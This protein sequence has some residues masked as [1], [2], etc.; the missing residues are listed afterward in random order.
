MIGG[1]FGLAFVVADAQTPLGSVAADLFRAI[2]V[3]GFAAFVVAGRRH[4]LRPVDGARSD[5]APEAELFGGRWRLIVAGEVL[6]LVAGFAVLW[7]MGAPREA[8]LPWT[9]LV[10]G[11]R[12]VAFRLAGVW[13]G[14]IAW[15]A[16]ALTALGFAGLVLAG[17]DHSDWVPLVSGVLAGAALLAGSLSAALLPAP[18]RDRPRPGDVEAGPRTTKDPSWTGPSE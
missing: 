8:Y 13:T 7:A 4:L 18:P 11:L 1:G 12:F 9:V 15:T 14:R 5:G 3:A 10:A 6:A 16:A 17:T 2:A